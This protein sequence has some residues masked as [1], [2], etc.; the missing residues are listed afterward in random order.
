MIGVWKYKTV[1][2]VLQFYR[3]QLVLPVDT[4]PDIAIE[5]EATQQQK[6]NYTKYWKLCA[7]FI[8]VRMLYF[9]IMKIMLKNAWLTLKTINN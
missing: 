2:T 9:Y 7:S 5:Q 3:S 4:E 6:N 1:T 8:C